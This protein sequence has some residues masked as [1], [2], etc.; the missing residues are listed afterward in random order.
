ML[1]KELGNHHSIEQENWA[2]WKSI[3]FLRRVRKLRWHG[4]VYW[5]VSLLKHAGWSPNHF[6]GDSIGRWGL[7]EV[8]RFRGSHEGGDPMM[9]LASL[10]DEEDRPEPSLTLPGEDTARRLMSANHEGSSRGTKS[11]SILILDF[12]TS[13]NARNKCLFFEPPSLWHFVIAAW[14]D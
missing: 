13:R 1:F 10:Q 11:A 12:L 7:Q 14:A 2:N 9:G 4:A 5:V 6:H 8:I 3:N